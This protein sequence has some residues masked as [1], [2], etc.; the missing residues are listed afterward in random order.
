M[1]GRTTLVEAQARSRRSSRFAEWLDGENG[2]RRGLTADQCVNNMNAYTAWRG[3]DRIKVEDA[4]ATTTTTAVVSASNGGGGIA[5]Y[6]PSESRNGQSNSNSSNSPH[7]SPVSTTQTSPTQRTS[8]TLHVQTPSHTSQSLQ[9]TSPSMC[10]PEPLPAGVGS[11]NEHGNSNGAK[12][13]PDL[14]SKDTFDAPVEGM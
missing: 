11:Q 2:W 13:E 14:P 4:A 3:K 9:N 10:G 8:Q 5:A 6:L 1:G 12:A 7:G